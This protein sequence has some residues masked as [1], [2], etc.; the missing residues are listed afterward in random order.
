MF[1]LCE[2]KVSSVIEELEEYYNDKFDEHPKN[3]NINKGSA[4]KMSDIN[5]KYYL[6][7]V[8]I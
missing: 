4:C 7:M 2:T 8:V 5:N 3:D 1:L 6:Y